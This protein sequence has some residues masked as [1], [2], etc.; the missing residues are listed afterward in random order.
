MLQLAFYFYLFI[1]CFSFSINWLKSQSNFSQPRF[2]WVD[3]SSNYH[4]TEL[5]Y[6]RVYSVFHEHALLLFLVV[7]CTPD[8]CFIMLYIS[9][10]TQQCYSQIALSLWDNVSTDC[11]LV[12]LFLFKWIHGIPSKQHDVLKEKEKTFYI[13]SE[14]RG[15]KK[16]VK[17]A[18]LYCR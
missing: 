14:K 5:I 15:T 1:Y 13:D 10:L 3:D 18:G 6:L 16:Q 12:Q 8:Q 2:S 17:H 4:V 11:T 9:V 7:S